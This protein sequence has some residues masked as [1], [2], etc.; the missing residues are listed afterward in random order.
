M[1]PLSTTSRFAGGGRQSLAHSAGGAPGFH[2]FLAQRV[3]VAGEE[4]DLLSVT[5]RQVRL[6]DGRADR[7]R[8]G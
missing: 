3:G 7:C 5:G 2:A 4:D 8:G 6:D 1:K